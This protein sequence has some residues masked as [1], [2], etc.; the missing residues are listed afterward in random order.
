M[1]HQG[2]N[3]IASTVDSFLRRREPRLVPVSALFS[4]A[5]AVER[6][7]A[8]LASAGL[9]RDL[10]DVVVS[11]KAASAFYPGIR[12]RP[13]RMTIPFAAI[14]AIEAL[15]VNIAFA[16]FTISF[17][18]FAAPG[19]TVFVQLLG[20]NM[21]GIGGAVAGAVFGFFQRRPPKWYH[22]RAAEAQDAIVVVVRARDMA[23]A[24]SVEQLLKRLQ[25]QEPRLETT[26]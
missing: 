23:H 13:A 10:I 2:R 1:R 9:P 16:L 18:E 3:S 21:A 6:A 25:G 24:Q 4:D 12:A 20:P 11:P 8:G 14:V 15:V 17:D 19:A 26:G 7:I 5:G 22:A